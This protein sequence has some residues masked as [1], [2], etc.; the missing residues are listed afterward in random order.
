MKLFIIL[1]I[2]LLTG[3]VATTQQAPQ[4]PVLTCDNCS[5]LVYYGPPTATQ[6]QAVTMASILTKGAVAIAGIAIGADKEKAIIE[7]VAD[8]GRYVAF[9]Q[10]APTVVQQPT[11]TIVEQPAPVIVDPVVVQP[12]IVKPEVVRMVD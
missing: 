2:I 3:C 10:P 8:A 7:T 6:S 5:G 4:N 9:N 12:Q 1:F 11:S